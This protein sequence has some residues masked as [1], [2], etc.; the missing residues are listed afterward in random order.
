[1]RFELTQLVIHAKACTTK[2]PVQAL[3]VGGKLL[4]LNNFFSFQ[5]KTKIAAATSCSMRFELTLLVIHAK[6]CTTKP[7]GQACAVGG[8]LLILTSSFSF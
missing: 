2:Q 5:F 6:A 8:K 7:L 3:A 4:I 1:M